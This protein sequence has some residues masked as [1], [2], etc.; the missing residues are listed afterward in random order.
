[1]P[2]KQPTELYCRRLRRMVP[3]DNFSAKMQKETVDSKRESLRDALHYE[4]VEKVKN[5][6]TRK[7][8]VHQELE[9]TITKIQYDDK[10][11]GCKRM[12]DVVDMLEAKYAPKKK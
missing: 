10:K 6:N 3:F 11:S 7:F 8:S 12:R 2:F 5:S 9:P 4:T 1:M